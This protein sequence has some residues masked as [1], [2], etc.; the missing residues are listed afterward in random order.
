MPLLVDGQRYI[1]QRRDVGHADQAQA[2]VF[3]AGGVG[4]VILRLLVQLPR[5]LQHQAGKVLTPLGLFHAV[6]GVG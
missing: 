6:P 2:D 1:E 4:A 5:L 3:A